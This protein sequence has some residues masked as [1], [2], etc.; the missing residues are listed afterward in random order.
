MG[1]TARSATAVRRPAVTA[2]VLAALTAS[3]V[4]AAPVGA[5]ATTTIVS[6]GSG[7]TD[8]STSSDATATPPALIGRTADVDRSAAGPKVERPQDAPSLAEDSANTSTV[9]GTDLQDTTQ[10][11]QTAQTYPQCTYPIG[12]Y[13]EATVGE[14]TGIGAPIVEPG[15]ELIGLV[16][17]VEWGDG[18][19]TTVSGNVP[20]PHVYTT[21]GT[22]TATL[23]ESGLLGPIGGPYEPCYSQYPF[24]FQIFDLP[25]VSVQDI[26]HDEGNDPST[27]DVTVQLSR[28]RTIGV[29]V[30]YATADGTATSPSDYGSR[31]GTLTFPAGTTSAT[32]SVPIVGDALVEEDENFD[33]VLSNATGARAT[34]SRLGTVTIVNDDTPPSAAFDF[35]VRPHGIVDFDASRSRVGSGGSLLKE[36]HWTFGD[37]TTETTTGPDV[38]HEFADLAEV[39]VELYVT[40]EAGNRSAVVAHRTDPCAPDVAARNGEEYA[41]LVRCVEARLPDRNP[42]EILST[43][44]QLYHGHEAWSFAPK[45]QWPDIIPCGLPVANPRPALSTKLVNRL[46]EA[47]TSVIDGDVGHLFPGLEA[48]ECPSKSF[49]LFP[50]KAG[51]PVGWWT[52]NMTNYSA[53]TWGG[54]LTAAVGVRTHDKVVKGIDQPWSHYIGPLHSRTSFQDLRGDVDSLVLGYAVGGK[55]C[56]AAPGPVP[57]TQ[58]VSSAISRYYATTPNA[59]S[60]YR[61]NRIGCF[62]SIISYGVASPPVAPAQLEAAHTAQV[63]E[64]A[65]PYYLDHDDVSTSPFVGLAT[66]KVNSGEAV[67]I[68]LDWLHTE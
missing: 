20:V 62:T 23:T 67:Q 32:V 11:L 38:R 8:G 21:P 34:G 56:T 28:S 66:L 63:L 15:A 33:V 37:G 13:V 16:T 45:A 46:R 57:W 49:T 52:V 53:A 24:T 3:L 68:F 59:M 6:G 48:M 14:E 17:R 65:K 36:F 30:D 19:E 5:T 42:R 31:S 35:T 22:Y 50:R 61:L 2:M 12:T 58:K 18:T 44:R 47:Q 25:S 41:G 54:D 40:D 26:S 43:M 10:S 29:T 39:D 55:N 51:V 4:V 7:Q 60:A 64:F 1:S 9:E 27:V